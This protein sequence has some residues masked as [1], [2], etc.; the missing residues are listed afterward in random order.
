MKRQLITWGAAL[1]CLSVTGTVRSQDQNAPPPQSDPSQQQYGQQERRR[2]ASEAS[3]EAMAQG[4]PTKF[5]K[6]S[7]L[8][9]MEV[10]NDQGETLGDIKDIVINPDNGTVAYA[11]MSTG[12]VLGVGERLLAVPLTAFRRSQDQTHLVLQA[13]KNNIAQAQGIGNNW[14]SVQHPTFG[15]TPFWQQSPGGI[16]E[17]RNMSE[18]NEMHETMPPNQ[19]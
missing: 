14:P 11:V 15:A 5:N 7:K 16:K 3:A 10:K 18:T 8:I 12:G 17:M 9:G 1:V 4:Q 19:R 2:S 13:S 6:A